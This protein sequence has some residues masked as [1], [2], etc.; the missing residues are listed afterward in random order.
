LSQY[1]EALQA[2]KKGRIAKAMFKLEKW[3]QMQQ[4]KLDVQHAL[5]YMYILHSTNFHQYFINWII[6]L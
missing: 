6:L 1:E 2:L 5:K 3:L 4:H